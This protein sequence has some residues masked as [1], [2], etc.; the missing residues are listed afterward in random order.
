MTYRNA[1]KE[2][3]ASILPSVVTLYGSKDKPAIRQAWADWIDML[4][5]NREITDK[6]AN[7]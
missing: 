3:K 4:H 1:L 6:Q 5:R 7:N 2:F